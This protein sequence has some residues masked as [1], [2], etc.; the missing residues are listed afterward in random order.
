MIV[1][2]LVTLGSPEQ[3][4]GGYLYHRRLADAAAEHDARVEFVS[5]RFTRNPFQ[6]LADVVLVDSIAAA[7]AAPWA[8]R[9]SFEPP[10]A[11]ILHQPPGGIDHGMARRSVQARLDRSLYHRCRL[12]IAASAALG[13]EL[14][15][16]HGLPAERIV[17]IAPGCDVAPLPEEG[18]DLRAGRRVAFLSIGNWV[19]RKGTLELLEAYAGLPAD[20]ATLHLAGRHDVEP[21]YAA[22]V[23]DRLATPD[24][25]GRVVDHGPVSRDEVARL[26]RGADVFVLPSYQEPYG[27]VYG[28][29]LAAGLPAVGWRAGNLPHLIDDGREGIVLEPGDI[30]G[31][32]A[33]LQRLAV[34][35]GW[36]ARLTAAAQERGTRLP[37]WDDTAMAFFTQLR[38]LAAGQ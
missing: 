30:T 31:L 29:A 6:G 1:I 20:L 32:R 13:D 22:R 26:Y 17:V 2:S 7:V 12:L 15:N 5:A 23:M 14:I 9:R 19:E 25:T 35:D 27:T 34:D 10:L 11:A 8:W 28:E 24:L 36:R 16:R 37:T 18:P 21:R 38:Q 3:L 33:A 4:T